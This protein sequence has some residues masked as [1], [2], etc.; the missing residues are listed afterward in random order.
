MASAL[1]WAADGGHDQIVSLLL[2]H[3]NPADVNIRDHRGVTALISA[4]EQGYRKV[5]KLLLADVRTDVNIQV[6]RDL[7]VFLVSHIF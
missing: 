3:R 5:V 2:D 7:R 6:N 4:S 1:I